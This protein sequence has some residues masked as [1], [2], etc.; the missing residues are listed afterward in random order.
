VWYWALLWL[1]GPFVLGDALG[2][3][4]ARGMARVYALLGLGLLIGF[5]FVLAIY[6]TSPS[7]YQHDPSRCSDCGEYWGRW[8]E[9]AVPIFFAAVGYLCYLLGIGAGA[10]GRAVVMTSREER[11]SGVDWRQRLLTSLLA[12]FVASGVVLTI[13]LLVVNPN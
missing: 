7:D 3:P 10:A 6:L 5:L 13:I 8:W 11:Q 4:F 1:G 9:P 12:A 2:A